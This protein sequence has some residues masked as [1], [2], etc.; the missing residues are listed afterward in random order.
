M[1]P[2][3]TDPADPPE[4]R[5]RSRVSAPGPATPQRILVV[6]SDHRV[7]DSIAGL[8]ALSDG[9]EVI[10]MT[11]DAHETLDAVRRSGPG[12]LIIDPYLPDLG[13]G[14]ALVS[15]LRAFAPSL[16]IVATCREGGHDDASLAAGADICVERSG[17]PA[18]FQDAL[19]AAARPVV[20]RSRAPRTSPR[21]A[22]RA[23]DASVRH[24]RRGIDA[25]S[26]APKG[27]AE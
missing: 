17:D 14:L 4:R 1:S 13:S 6:D 12:V 3:A 10:G 19:V 18:V 7:R 24:P 9:I 25:A 15:A 20:R 5:A 16:R 11:S 23:A 26:T 22:P 8:I 27:V 2:R 21:P